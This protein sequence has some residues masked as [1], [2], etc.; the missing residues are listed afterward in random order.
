GETTLST[1]HIVRDLGSGQHLIAK[2]LKDASPSVC[3]Q[4]I[5]AAVRHGRLQH[6]NIVQTVDYEKNSDGMPFFIEECIEGITLAELIDEVG[7][8]EDDEEIELFLSQICRALEHAHAQGIVHGG[9]KPSNVMLTQI[10]DQVLVKLLDFGAINYSREM[11]ANLGR[12]ESIDYLSPEQLEGQEPSQ[13]SDVYSLAVLAYQLITGYLPFDDTIESDEER[14]DPQSVSE[15]RP[16]IASAEKLDT[17]LYQALK[18]D[19]QE[20]LESI[21]AFNQLVESWYESMKDQDE[22]MSGVFE[23]IT[24]EAQVEPVAPELDKADV[25]VTK[26]IIELEPIVIEE[27]LTQPEPEPESEVDVTSTLIEMET[28]E[29]GQRLT[30]PDESEPEENLPV[31]PETVKV[32]S[33]EDMRKL[34]LD[35]D[36]QQ[37]QEPKI[38]EPLSAAD[39]SPIEIVKKDEAAVSSGDLGSEYDLLD[40]LFELDEES[41]NESEQESDHDGIAIQVRQG[42]PGISNLGAQIDNAEFD[43][44]AVKQLELEENK[45]LSESGRHSS[46]QTLKALI[47]P[48]SLNVSTPLPLSASISEQTTVNARTRLKKA[49]LTKRRKPT[50]Q[51]T[52]NRLMALKQTQVIQEEKIITRFSESFAQEG[53]KQS[54]TMLVG[55]LVASVVVFAI[56][57]FFLLTNL[58]VV[59]R[60]WTDA[61]KQ[62]IALMNDK[63]KTDNEIVDQKAV[64]QADLLS[65]EKTGVESSIEAK[66]KS[67]GKTSTA[68]AGKSRRIPNFKVERNFVSKEMI[69]P[70][71]GV[72][73]QKPIKSSDVVLPYLFNKEDAE[74]VESTNDPKYRP[75]PRDTDSEV[76]EIKAD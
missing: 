20:R 11:P 8:L 62:V 9:L 60:M 71:G 69:A 49:R 3:E 21:S 58:D 18:R 6:E 67:N 40:D 14:P 24:P 12:L 76:L 56:S 75:P 19:P 38:I 32:A 51:S 15:S 46:P 55:K 33:N 10:G 23:Q 13:Q 45:V 27:R 43:V 50:V 1:T 52:M 5:D 72:N 25:D 26:T 4:F 31:E 39:L 42:E 73:S 37:E 41:Q 16:D 36:Q 64:D 65:S 22:Q 63:E 48:E 53:P 34:F 54:P 61:S 17:L 29:I 57:L 68:I 70:K 30:E 2:T 35:L 44:E 66:S 74:Q 47:A 28:I 59:G 7:T